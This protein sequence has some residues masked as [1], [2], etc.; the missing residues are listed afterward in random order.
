[1][2]YASRVAIATADPEWQEFRE[3]LKGTSTRQKLKALQEYHD[4]KMDNP[5]MSDEEAEHVITRIDNYLKALAR[6]GQLYRG[7]T[8]ETAMEQDWKLA[9][10][11]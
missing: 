5:E 4:S 6:G 1:M 3:S 11:K 10:R 2:T 7:V 8:Y 9:I